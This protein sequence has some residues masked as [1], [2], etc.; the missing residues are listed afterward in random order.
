MHDRRQNYSI[1]EETERERELVMISTRLEYDP[2]EKYY[3]VR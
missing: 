3:T 1:K 2:D